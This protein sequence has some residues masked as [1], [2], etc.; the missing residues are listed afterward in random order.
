MDLRVADSANI[1]RTSEALEQRRIIDVNGTSQKTPHNYIE[2]A[3]NREQKNISCEEMAPLLDENI[4]AVKPSNVTIIR[5]VD[6]K[7]TES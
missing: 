5:K 1:G 3:L 6:C 7:G 2:K 4:G